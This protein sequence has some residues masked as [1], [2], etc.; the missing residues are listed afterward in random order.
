MNLPDY[1]F[2]PAP[3]WLITVLHLVTLTLHFVAMN[4]IVGGIT[5]LL[6]AKLKDRWAHPLVQKFLKL[7][8][9]AM[10]ATVTLGVAPLLFVQVVYPKQVY[11]AS[12]V[13]GWFW[14]AIIFVAI[15]VYY[16]LYSAAFGKP[17]SPRKGLYLGLALLGMVYIAFVYSSVFALG[18]NPDLYRQ[19]YAADQSGLV[20]NT[21]VGSWIFRWLHMLLGALTVG[22][23]FVGWLGREHHEVYAASRTFFLY[24]MVVT[25]LI[26][27]VY[28]F[29]FG[30][31]LAP[32]MRG[33][34]IWSVTMG[35]VL[36][37]GSLHFFF[38]KRFGIAATMLFT[39]LF[40][41]VYTRHVVRLMYLGESFNPHD[42]PVRPQWSVFL[43]FLVF[44]L[45]AIGVIFYMCLLLLIC[46]RKSACPT[47]RYRKQVIPGAGTATS[48]PRRY[49][50]S[51]VNE[52]RRRGRRNLPRT[53]CGPV[54]RRPDRM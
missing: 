37:L 27:L 54:K 53:T 25:M 40:M 3:L 35:L 46:Q 9:T 39:S 4:F 23:F 38:K 50:A 52:S 51:G 44:F 7:F 42:I 2:L 36:S 8:P 10:A 31:Y 22:S 29:T 41:M 11:A 33:R 5:V 34:G 16:L 45:I 12:I 32:F 49:C 15:A 18:E 19:L 24:S 14:L 6:A 20:I 48:S 47:G 26:G 13:S 21:D 30:E 1:N 43:L 17:D 28:M